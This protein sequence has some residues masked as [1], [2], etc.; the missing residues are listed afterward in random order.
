MSHVTTVIP[1]YNGERFLGATLQCIVDQT[2]RPDLLVVIDDA[3]TDRTC[4][5]VEGF[6]K[7]H[8]EINCELRINE[9]NQGLFKNLNR[10]LQFASQTNYLHLL[11]ADDLVLPT[12][13]SRTV[14]VL[15]NASSLALAF[16]LTEAID[17][18][19]VLIPFL[20]QRTAD[21]VNHL[22]QSE[23]VKRQSELQTL[24]C[25]SVLLKTNHQKLPCEFRLDMP[26]TADCVF[27]AEIATHCR[28]ILEVGEVLCQIRS[29]PDSA[30]SRN[31]RQIQSWVLDEWKAME[32]GHQMRDGSV[33]ARWLRRQ[34]LLCL[35]AARSHVKIQG[36]R[37]ETPEFANQ[38]RSATQTVVTPIHWVLGR[39]AVGLRDVWHVFQTK[40]KI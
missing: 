26:Q 12:F 36:T 1:V 34:K 20:H 7:A 29:H 40:I 21:G 14:S 33:L 10:T 3:S 31:K 28:A 32:L 25:G 5:L 39:L 9:C 2:R 13:L 35:F 30:T 37:D 23:L 11:L 8:P 4:A 15:E 6:Q 27:Y 16:S 18:A 22:T 19:G 17:H 38:I 24:F